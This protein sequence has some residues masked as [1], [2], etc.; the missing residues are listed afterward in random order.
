MYLVVYKH[1]SDTEP[2]SYATVEMP[3]ATEAEAL[4]DFDTFFN[5]PSFPSKL[6]L[7]HKLEDN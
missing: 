3:V 7:I 4:E 6:I 1:Y 5:T 2:N